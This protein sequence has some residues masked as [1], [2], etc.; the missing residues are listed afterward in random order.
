MITYAQYMADPSKLHQAYFLQFVTPYVMGRVRKACKLDSLKAS[1]SPYFS[2]VYSCEDVWNKLAWIPT[3]ALQKMKACG[4]TNCNTISNG[5]CIAKA[6][7]RH[8][9]AT[10][11]MT[12]VRVG[13]ANFVSPS[14]ARTCY[15]SFG[16]SPEAVKAMIVNGD[17]VIGEPEARA[18]YC[19]VIDQDGRYH[20][21]VM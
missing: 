1:Q 16:E 14:A 13:T 19:L 9:V 15:A 8:W 7:A 18:G 10:A 20:Y 2:D 6:A 3:E 11:D 4:E 17:V 21:E 5:V 12:G